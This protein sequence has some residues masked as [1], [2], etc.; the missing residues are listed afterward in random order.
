MTGHVLDI[1][2]GMCFAVSI[3]DWLTAKRVDETP[4]VEHRE[5]EHSEADNAMNTDGVNH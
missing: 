3:P 2:D 4:H 1:G 5:V